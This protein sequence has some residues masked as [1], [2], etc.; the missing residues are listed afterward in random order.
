M[1]QSSTILLILAFLTVSI[2]DAQAQKKKS[3]INFEVSAGPGSLTEKLTKEISI[4]SSDRT[5]NG[6][7]KFGYDLKYKTMT[8]TAAL[9][10]QLDGFLTRI[11]GRY[12]KASFDKYKDYTDTDWLIMDPATFKDQNMYEGAFYLGFVINPKRRFQIPIMGGIGLGYISGEPINHLNLDF[13]YK[14]RAKYYI[15]NNVG[16]FVGVSGSYGG[17][18]IDNK[19][20]GPEA[21][22]WRERNRDDD[23]LIDVVTKRLYYEAGLTIMLGRK[24]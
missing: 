8:Y 4:S 11:E 7:K 12:T 23:D 22:K 9:E 13:L 14:V 21:E 6:K 17:S 3:V 24:K 18:A 19:N 2:L 16:L 15:T 20:P 10:Y 5:K 1:R